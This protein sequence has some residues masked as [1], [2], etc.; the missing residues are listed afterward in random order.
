MYYFFPLISGSFKTPNLNRPPAVTL[1]MEQL[2]GNKNK[3][4][5][6]CVNQ[7]IL[8]IYLF[9]GKVLRNLKGCYLALNP[10]DIFCGGGGGLLEFDERD[11]ES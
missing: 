6:F 7:R 10:K 5:G 2:L 9:P 4:E 1:K 3:G 11:E 8:F